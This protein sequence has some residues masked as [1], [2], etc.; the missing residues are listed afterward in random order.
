MGKKIKDESKPDKIEKDK[1]EEKRKAATT[2][3]YLHSR[4]HATMALSKLHGSGFDSVTAFER[5]EMTPIV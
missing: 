5:F 3:L 2:E 1:I 4:G